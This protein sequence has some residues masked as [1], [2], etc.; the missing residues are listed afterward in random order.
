[1]SKKI[2]SKLNY[3]RSRVST[4]QT[5]RAVS[6]DKT[7]WN[8]YR[9]GPR[10]K[11]GPNLNVKI[12]S[13]GNS[14]EGVGRHEG[15]VVF[16]PFTL[17]GEEV[18]VAPSKRKSSFINGKLVE[19][20]KSS[21]DRQTPQCEYF[22]QC[23][24]CDW[25]H[26]P[27]SMQTQAKTDALRDALQRIGKISS[28]PIQTIVPCDKPY[29]YRNRIQGVIKDKRFHFKQRG[30]NQLIPIHRCAIAEP[31][32][33]YYL[34]NSLDSAPAGR[35]EIAI[36][37]D[38]VSCLPTNEYNST[39]DGFR[40]VNT[41]VSD[42]LSE[43][44]RDIARQSTFAQ[45]IDL[46]CGRGSWTLKLAKDHVNTPFLGVDTS[47]DNIRLARQQAQAAGM[48]N[49]SFQQAQVENLIK[50]LPLSESLCIVDPPRAGLDARVTQ[51]LSDNPPKRLIY[52]SCHPA[53]LARD[54]L[55]LTNNAFELVSVTPLDMFPQT[56]HLESVS[57][58]QRI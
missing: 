52:V 54:L 23:G 29:H 38:G 6:K 1:M 33:N 34:Q 45:G 41:L 10:P 55:V 32:I 14:G 48:T 43:Q 28:P 46:Y 2:D 49:V 16:V 35:V 20:L 7:G 31:D 53:S 18:L 4:A 30:S 12:E 5:P 58:L 39:T 25:Q 44:V 22:T 15:K 36:N 8:K 50:D 57:V 3:S 24:G 21:S 42:A 13:L 11:T 19:I 9:R 56:A 40:Q 47:A 17:P 51:A 27:Y 26:V 37:S